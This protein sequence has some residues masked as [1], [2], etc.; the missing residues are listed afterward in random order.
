MI[1]AFANLHEYFVSQCLLSLNLP[2]GVL[3]KW[4]FLLSNLVFSSQSWGNCWLH[5][6]SHI[7]FFISDSFL[8]IPYSDH[9]LISYLV[10]DPLILLS[11]WRYVKIFWDTKVTEYVETMPY[12]VI[13]FWGKKLTKISPF[14]DIS[15]NQKFEKIFFFPKV[16]WARKLV[17]TIQL[18]FHCCHHTSEENTAFEML[19][20]SSKTS[21]K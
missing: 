11:H 12:F 17:E 3:W 14:K 18:F 20:W 6:L 21:K 13:N 1:S 16:F 8:I 4:I 5:L 9:I 7:A 10:S 15:W 2:P 19:F